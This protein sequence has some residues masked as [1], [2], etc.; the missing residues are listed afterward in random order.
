MKHPVQ[1]G[2]LTVLRVSLALMER[3]EVVL[4]PISDNSRYDLALDRDGRLFR[5]QCKTGRLRNG[6]VAFNTCSTSLS[7][8]GGRRR[9]YIGQIDAFGVYCEG[10]VYLVPIDRVVGRTSQYLRVAQVKKLGR[11]RL[12]AIEFEV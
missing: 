1:K 5:V 7:V 2:D 9:D 12:L 11:S 3:G 8:Y 4:K 10:K 6:A